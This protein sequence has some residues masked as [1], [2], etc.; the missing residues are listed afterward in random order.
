MNFASAAALY[1][2]VSKEMGDELV[3]PG[4]ENYYQKVTVFTDAGLHAR[5][6]RWA[7]L[8]PRAA[9]EAFNVLNGDVESWMNLWPR[10]AKYFGLTVSADQFQRPTPLASERP[11]VPNPPISV[12]AS[13]I[14][15]EGRTPQSYVRNRINLSSGRSNKMCRRRGRS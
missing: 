7:A 15:L 14:G 11:L 9:N 10:L 3:F 1:A 4:S 6:C 2:A 8:E 13:A 12:H 5:F